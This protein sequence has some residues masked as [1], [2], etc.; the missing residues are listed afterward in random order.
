MDSQLRTRIDDEIEQL[1]AELYR[2]ASIWSRT[3]TPDEMLDLEQE[4]QTTLNAF[5]S[6]VVGVMLAAIH[7][8]KA[9]VAACRTQALYP[10]SINVAWLKVSVRSLGGHE[11]RIRTPYIISGRKKAGRRHKKG[12]R[13]RD[14]KGTYPVLRRL[15][16][17]G[18]AT[19]ALLAEVNRQLA[20]G[21]SGAEAQ[22]RLDKRDIVLD[23]KTAR[24]YI[25]DFASI[26]LWQ[27]QFAA[28]NLDQVEVV[29]PPY[30]AGKRVVIGIDGGRLRIRVNKK[31]CREA[32]NKW[33]SFTTDK[34]EPKLF[35]IYTVDQKG[36]KEREGEVIYDGTVLSVRQLFALLKLRLKEL[37]IAQAE[38]V[39]IIGDGARWIWKGAAKLQESFVPKGIRVVEIVDWAHA[40]GTLTNPAKL[41]IKEFSQRQKWLRQIRELLKKGEV[42]KVVAAL[43]DLDRSRDK[44]NV[45]RKA[46]EY[47]QTHQARMQYARFRSEGLPI[48]SGVIESGVRRIVGLRMKGASIFWRPENAE[49]ILYLRCQIKSGRWLAFVKSTLSQ[50]AANMSIPFAEA[51]QIREQIAADFLGSHPP[52]YAVRSRNEVIRWARDLLEAGT[53]LIIDTE[54]TGLGDNDEVIQLAVV[55]LESHVLFETLLRPTMPVSLGARAVHGI[56]DETL[57]SAPTFS[58]LYHTIAS[59]ISK[60]HLIAYNA[61]FDRRILM[62]TCQK[63]GLSKFEVAGWDCV[64]GQY[65]R[66]EDGCHG[67]DDFK[68]HSLS[69]AC[70]RQGITINES[71]DAVED[72]LLTLELIKMMAGAD[73][74]VKKGRL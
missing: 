24:R 13:S 30:L 37:G 42:N 56:T 10:G 31:D 7:R 51:L 60:R 14:G 22:E 62:Q 5:H 48:G 20:D 32:K 67:T 23:P 38:L 66:F 15:G 29:E 40:I 25:R 64:M 1:K 55:D 65:A 34:C 6:K 46:I 43:S 63:Y 12:Q 41:G 57:A 44:G 53:S 27:R 73:E 50:W 18:R 11:V 9:F 35:V 2:K 47:F 74:D 19:P 45:I 49:E 28:S 36:R 72:C 17:V 54:T 16:V 71:H 68:R 69:A 61:E 58:D 52:I 59:L 26:A 4:L 70:A 39:V 21:P 8:D 33:P 3:R